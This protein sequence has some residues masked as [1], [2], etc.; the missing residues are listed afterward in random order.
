MSLCDFRHTTGPSGHCLPSR[1]R[2][3]DWRAVSDGET[4]PGKEDFNETLLL[5]SRHATQAE[6]NVQIG[7]ELSVDG[8][9]H[10]TTVGN[11]VRD[12]SHVRQDDP[13]VVWY[14]DVLK[15]N[16]PSGNGS[17]LSER[18]RLVSALLSFWFSCTSSRSLC[19]HRMSIHKPIGAIGL[20]MR[21]FKIGEDWRHHGYH[22]QT[23][24]YTSCSTNRPTDWWLD[25]SC[26]YRVLLEGESSLWSCDLLDITPAKLFA[27][28]QFGP[29]GCTLGRCR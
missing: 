19:C 15:H 11:W 21:H 8:M 1:Q 17:P 13:N 18:V 5:L 22:H 26:R 16:D 3:S 14:T 7:N 9:Q 10:D 29:P 27:Y 28:I 25:S 6:G 2:P 12:A 24:Q 4:I 20:W 23:V